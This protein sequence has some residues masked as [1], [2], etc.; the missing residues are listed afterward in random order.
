MRRPLSGICFCQWRRVK[1][2][3]QHGIE[4]FRVGLVVG[5]PKEAEEL[6][7][8]QMRQR[9]DLQPRQRDVIVVEID[10]DDLLRIRGQIIHH[11]A[12]ARRD[13]DEPVMRFQR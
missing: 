5:V 12:A 2:V 3:A 1:L 9:G 6:V 13:G 8:R 11:I 4:N 10:G 7:E